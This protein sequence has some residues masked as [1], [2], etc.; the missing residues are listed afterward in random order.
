MIAP[1]ER[2]SLRNT[3]AAPVVS[4][5]PN[6][7]I[8][9]I[10]SIHYRTCLITD[11]NQTPAR[12]GKAGEPRMVT[13]AAG[14]FGVSF[15]RRRKFSIAPRH[16]ESKRRL[17][18]LPAMKNQRPPLGPFDREYRFAMFPPRRP[19]RVLWTERSFFGRSRL[20]TSAAA[21]R[22]AQSPQFV[23]LD[24]SRRIAF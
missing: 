14:S 19:Q 2:R 3:Q 6:C 8:N 22:A 5:P 7:E 20:L 16:A 21:P 23:N 10:K 1:A 15:G 13:P 24:L 18:S 4:I 12:A 9:A 17:G 11:T